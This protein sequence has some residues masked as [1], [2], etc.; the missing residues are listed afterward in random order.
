M[1][2]GESPGRS[3]KGPGLLIG[4]LVLLVAVNGLMTARAARAA[5]PPGGPQRPANLTLSQSGA[6]FIASFEG[7][8]A[9]PYNAYA[10]VRSCTI[11]Y[12]HVIHAGA[13]TG[14]DLRTWGSITTRQGQALLQSDVDRT[15]VPALRAGIPATP[16]TQ[17]QFDALVDWIYNE[18]PAY[19]TLRSSVRSALRASPPD[20]ASVPAGLMRYVKAAGTRVCGL[21]RRR[22][23]EVHL[24]STGSYARLSPACPPGYESGPAARPSRATSAGPRSS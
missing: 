24:W 15:L 4:G 1:A 3:G 14:A 6:A 20:Y 7:F 8:S 12:G 19:I 17:P 11:G 16:L 9:A 18:G 23:S 2:R 13:C 5:Q 22:V 10:P 21:Y